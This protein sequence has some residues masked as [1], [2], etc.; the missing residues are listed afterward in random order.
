MSAKNL[1][2]KGRL[3]SETIAYRCS[4]AEREELDKRWRLLGYQTKQ[5]YVLDAVLHNKVTAKGN[6]MMLVNFRK[7]L[8]GILAE[9]ERL[10]VASEIDEDLFTPINTM[11]EILEAFKVNEEKNRKTKRKDKFLERRM[12]RD[13]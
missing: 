5:D 3:R 6:P 2:P 4:P 1:D 10:D 11:L 8:S 13:V 7:E 12:Y 9:L